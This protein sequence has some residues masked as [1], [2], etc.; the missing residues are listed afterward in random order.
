MRVFITT[1]LSIIIINNCI[2]QNNY[3]I[4]NP[5]GGI[6]GYF[7]S[8]VELDSM[9]D[10][11]FN[12]I[13]NFH[14]DSIYNLTCFLKHGSTYTL[15][16]TSGSHSVSTLAAWIDWDNNGTLSS[17]EKLD[18]D[19]TSV[20]YERRSLT[21]TVPQNSVNGK[22]RLR[23]RSTNSSNINACN[24]YT[25]GQ[26]ADYTIT[27]LN[28]LFEY[29][30]YPGW[31]SSGTGNNFI[32]GVKLSN[33][34]K[35]NT[36]GINGPVYSDYSD[37]NSNLTRCTSYYLKISG[38]FSSNDDSVFAFIDYNE[39][40]IFED[41]E[42]IGKIGF[43]S[44]I[45]TDST[46][47]NIIS[48]A[49]IFRLRIIYYSDSDI[50]E[51]EDY[52]AV[53]S[54]NAV[55]GMPSSEIGSD[56]IFDCDTDCF[57]YG[58]I[59]S[60]KFY[61][62][63][64]GDP[65]YRLWSIPGAIPPTSTVK[66]PVFTFPSSG[67]YLVTLMDSNSLG[68]DVVTSEIYI[69]NPVTNFSLGSDTS[70]CSGGSLLLSAPSG[71]CYSYL[72]S[73]GAT[74]REIYASTSG[75]FSV[76]ITTCVEN[77][78]PAYDELDI[79]F[80]P[81]IYTVTGG[82]SSCTGSAAGFNVGVNNSQTGIKYQLY[83]N[84]NASGSPVIG[85]GNPIN[86]GLQL[87]AGTY[88]VTGIDTVLSCSTAMDGNAYINFGFPPAV[89]N[90]SGGGS[91]C[92]GG[93]G[94]PIEIDSSE[95]NARYQL[96]CNGIITGGTVTGNGGL[97]TF[98]NQTNPGVYS[99][100]ATYINTSCS[101]TMNGV[102]NVNTQPAPE[103]FNISGGG[104]FCGGTT[105]AAVEL[106]S[107]HAGDVYELFLDGNPTG[108]TL[109]GTGHP[110]VFS[111]LINS[112]DYTIVA[113]DT[114]VCTSEMHGSAN[115]NLI[116]FPY[117]FNLTGGGTFCEGENFGN[118]I[119]DSSQYWVRYQLYRDSSFVG[120]SLNGTGGALNFGNQTTP[121]VYYVIGSH[122]LTA[123]YLPMSGTP[124]LIVQPIP[125]I[126]NVTGGGHYCS[127]DSGVSVGLSYSDTSIQY[128]LYHNGIISGTPV[129]G[130]GGPLDFG[131]QSSVGVYTVVAT[132]INS[133]CIEIMN[134]LAIV[135]VDSVPVA[136]IVSILPD[137]MCIYQSPVPLAGSPA[138]GTFSGYGITNNIFYPANA[139]AGIVPITY[140][141][142]DS[143]TGCEANDF[144]SIAVDLCIGI[145]EYENQ[146][147]VSLFPNP[148]AH[149]L[150][151]EFSLKD[152]TEITVEIINEIGETIG[153]YNFG[154]ETGNF[155]MTIDVS[156]YPDGIYIVRFIL[157]NKVESRKIV[158]HHD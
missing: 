25:Y 60:A 9:R 101:D 14:N 49:G 50:V 74:T 62:N 76:T 71:T 105:L 112:G 152:E 128:Q 33:L 141:Y 63:S 36:G 84:G 98:P 91:F 89:V 119:L 103:I 34:D 77:Q 102:A 136:K 100:I 115:L 66:N 108:D 124:T 12:D 37:L 127:N 58:C 87:L 126:Y 1:L 54:G 148:S 92:F 10:S 139:G 11:V 109:V 116:P 121:G 138:G 88:S 70:I 145:D 65:V 113:S 43:A 140:T 45:S 38:D 99:V 39:N 24:N 55:T 61:D 8:K 114:S 97:L 21:F 29:D 48:V 42:V 2:A 118:I 143:I 117:P 20:D 93:A 69:S 132:G 53:I 146:R 125:A 17:S 18:E 5:S 154:R 129:M 131:L 4:P 156:E 64:C 82:G 83:L 85:T 135:A 81:R 26:I 59:G 90:V 51:V 28:P 52:T 57:F 158:I 107:S 144:D 16:V 80:S 94:V 130:T 47:V 153:R 123:C 110:L 86:F 41:N 35:Q 22:L 44:G 134:N 40:G 111:Y 137:T 122:T 13:Y 142:T 95:I 155:S 19:I 67:I 7:I 3:C 27:V 56:L 78:C 68:T 96:Y 79:S 149:Y 150:I 157:D 106:D 23:V 133:S 147:Y 72:W 6:N 104:S 31:E 32:D 15:F 75:T 120:N 151:S 46:L 30:F 73:T